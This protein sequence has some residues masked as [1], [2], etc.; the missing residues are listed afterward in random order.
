VPEMAERSWCQPPLRGGVTDGKPRDFVR[1]YSVPTGKQRA[2]KRRA[3]A[4]FREA[5]F[6]VL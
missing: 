5:E 2:A 1:G 6:V 3:E 4:R